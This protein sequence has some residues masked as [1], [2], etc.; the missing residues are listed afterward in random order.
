MKA[1]NVVIEYMEKEYRPYSV[2]DLVLNLHNR[3][4]KALMIKILDDLVDENL[5]IVKRYGKL[6]YY[7]NVERKLDE[8]IIPISLEQLK[9][10]SGEIEIIDKDVLQ[11][12]GGMLFV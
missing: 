6:A 8:N 7:C 10:L 9:E 3:I 4:P 5:M 11:Y 12:K 1:K 2:T